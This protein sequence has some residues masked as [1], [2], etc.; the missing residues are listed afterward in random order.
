MAPDYGRG[1]SRVGS[2]VRRVSLCVVSAV[3][4]H[5]DGS[6]GSYGGYE[7]LARPHLHLSSQVKKGTWFEEDP[8]LVRDVDAR[9]QRKIVP[10]DKLDLVR[11]RA[12]PVDRL[13]TSLSTFNAR[14]AYVR[15]FDRSIPK[16]SASRESLG[17][18]WSSF[19]RLRHLGE[20]SMDTC[21][22]LTFARCSSRPWHRL[23]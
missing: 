15:R 3:T 18:S 9:I 14:I 1:E 2:S 19:T 6:R 22:S 11:P 13:E 10:W 20:A 8:G 7:L 12:L 5:N 16:L 17:G 4:L 21:F 23:T